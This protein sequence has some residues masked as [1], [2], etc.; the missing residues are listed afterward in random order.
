MVLFGLV[1]NSTACWVSISVW[2]WCAVFCCRPETGNPESWNPAELQS[3]VNEFLDLPNF[4]LLYV[5]LRIPIFRP[6]SPYWFNS[7][8]GIGVTGMN[9]F[10]PMEPLH[11]G[12]RKLFSFEMLQ[13]LR[14]PMFLQVSCEVSLTSGK[15]MFNLQVYNASN[16]I[17]L[18]HRFG[19]VLEMFYL[20]CVISSKTHLVLDWATGDKHFWKC[21]TTWL[22]SHI[23]CAG[24]GW[25]MMS[26]ASDHCKS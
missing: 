20:K 2:E 14:Q 3:R 15:K 11:T 21:Q 17:H 9:P 24:G 5:P 22:S 10:Q 6:L 23:D 26:P 18:A 12:L 25:P 8:S 13:N 1:P 7:V 16:T 4:S 19:M